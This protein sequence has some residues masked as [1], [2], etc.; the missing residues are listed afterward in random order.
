MKFCEVCGCEIGTRDG[1]NRCS[2][3]DEIEAASKAKRAKAN[4][5]RR[6]RESVL[7][8]CGLVKVRGAMGGTY[9]E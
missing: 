9:W 6:E 5:A 1:D 8:D 4:K 3:C 2:S 7:R